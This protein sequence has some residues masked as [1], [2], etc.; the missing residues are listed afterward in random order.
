MLPE[1]LG[2]G[3]PVL[4]IDVGGTTTKAVALAADGTF[5]DVVRRATP[6]VSAD[7]EEIVTLVERLLHDTAPQPR[8]LIALAVPGIVDERRGIAVR[9]DNLGWRDSPLPELVRRR[10]GHR[11]VLLHD[12]RASGRAE[13]ALGA[14][15]GLT[16]AVIVTIG[17]GISAALRVQG[18]DVVRGG[19]AGELGHVVVEPGGEPCA[20]GNRGCLEAIASGLAIERRY[21]ALSGYTAQGADEVL[22]RADGGDHHARFVWESALDAL[23]TAIAHIDG[24]LA[25]QAV[26]LAGGLAEAGDRLLQPLRERIRSV[27]PA[28]RA[29]LRLSPHGRDAGLLGAAL[30]GRAGAEER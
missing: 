13:F 25:P 27:F 28:Q 23:A 12:V 6:V 7:G 30:G 1:R 18:R 8:S 14:A 26:V 11:A 3:S 10:T 9:A 4:A 17:T 24:L 16:D 2:P 20:C 21:R 19:Y 15:S 29:E 5:G 22:L